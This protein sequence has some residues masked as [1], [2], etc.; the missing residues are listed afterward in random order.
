M[1]IIHT[2]PNGE[3]SKLR[4]SSFIPQTQHLQ[5]NF[6]TDTIRTFMHIMHYRDNTDSG[7]FIFNQHAKLTTE[8][9]IDIFLY[10][11]LHKDKLYNVN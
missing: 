1:I 2:M 5:A 9:L 3:N 11:L 8:T 7:V 6:M 4:I 10:T